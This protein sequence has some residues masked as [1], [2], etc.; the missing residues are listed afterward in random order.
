MVVAQG[1]GGA[2]IELLHGEEAR[3]LAEEAPTDDCSPDASLEELCIGYESH[4]FVALSNC[5]HASGYLLAFAAIG[6]ALL[7][8]SS[9]QWTSLQRAECL[10]WVLPLWYLYAWLGHFFVQKDIP[11]ALLHGRTVSEP[12]ELACTVAVAALH[13]AVLP[14]APFFVKEQ[15]TGATK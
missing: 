15:K 13:M 11:A 14:T 2:V 8:P 4:H 7:R 6:A 3:K 10:L 12:W 5:F 9:S 1:Y